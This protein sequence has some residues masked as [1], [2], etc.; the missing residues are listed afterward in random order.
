MTVHSQIWKGLRR[1]DSHNSDINT[2]KLLGWA[3]WLQR[4]TTIK[5]HKPCLFVRE[6][7]SGF[8]Q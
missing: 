6:S 4:G 8:R 2:G 5:V 3:M 1:E 7:D